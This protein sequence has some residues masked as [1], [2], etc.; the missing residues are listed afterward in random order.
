ILRAA[1][2]VDVTSHPMGE[3]YERKYGVKSGVLHRG[4][5]VPP[6]PSP[7]YDLTRDGLSV[8]I[9]GN[10]YSYQQLPVLGRALA[11]AAARHGVAG[12]IVVCGEGYGARLRDEMKGSVEV[13]VTGHIPE[14]ECIARLQRCGLLYLNYPFGRLNRVLRETSFPVK[15]STYI[16]A[17]RPILL[18]APDGTSVK[19]LPK[20]RKYC[21]AWD[22][23]DPEDGAS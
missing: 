11:L 22:T 18:H 6:S 17:S 12:R 23:L 15:L 21:C 9:L 20:D 7:A 3:F 16:Y 13:E 10:T 5:T 4:L 8:G 19:E 14:Q 2:T 1:K